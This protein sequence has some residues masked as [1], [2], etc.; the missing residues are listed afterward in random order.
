MSV[1]KLEHFDLGKDDWNLYVDR[2]EQYFIVNDVKPA[3][4]VAT[5][6][7]VIGSDA[8]ELMVNLCTPVK[9]S[10]KSYE[11]LVDVMRRHLQ[12]KPSVLAERFKFRQRVQRD[13]SVAEYAAALKKLTKYCGFCSKTLLENLRD[14]FVCGISSDCI[15]QRMFAEDNITFD[16]AF[17]LAVTMEAAE[18][19]AALVEGRTR[20]L[21]DGGP[22]AEASINQ[23]TSRN[24]GTGRRGMYLQKYMNVGTRE[25]VLSN[26]TSDISGAI[27]S[28]RSDN[29]INDFARQKKGTTFKQVCDVCGA[30]HQ[31]NRC[32]F[33]LYIC[34]VCNKQ[35][36]LKK[37][38][39]LLQRQVSLNNVQEDSPAG[40]DNEG[41]GSEEFQIL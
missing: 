39:P 38:C 37:V 7:T 20:R 36:H 9:P 28:R 19:D 15:R 30:N 5:L 14:Q 35:G 11:E 31:V 10:A 33:R 3:I 41:S 6:I 16:S 13:E 26:G 21:G 24:R 8:Y 4:R 18:A 32:K 34:R 29:N 17:K 40:T 12:P 22:E 23:I 27:I 2:L 1:G 25:P